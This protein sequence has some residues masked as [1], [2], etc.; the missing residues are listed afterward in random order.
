MFY[1][2][3]IAIGPDD[4]EMPSAQI[5]DSALA[6]DVFPS[7]YDCIGDNQNRPVK[8]LAKESLVDYVFTPASDIVRNK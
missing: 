5:S 3:R 1:S 6:R 8:W 4:S 7:D 2:S